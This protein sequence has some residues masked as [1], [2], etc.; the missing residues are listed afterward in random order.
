[1][2]KAEAYAAK[3]A[4]GNLGNDTEESDLDD[5]DQRRLMEATPTTR[6]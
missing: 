2:A 4:F 5:D 3:H 1:M 6:K